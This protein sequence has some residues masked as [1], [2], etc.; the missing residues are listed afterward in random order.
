M[1]E[2]IQTHLALE[3][4]EEIVDTLIAQLNTFDPAV[5]AQ[6]NAAY[7]TLQTDYPANGTRYQQGGVVARFLQTLANIPEVQAVIGPL[8]DT[9]RVPVR[10]GGLADS[11]ATLLDRLPPTL[12]SPPR[13]MASPPLAMDPPPPPPAPAPGPPDSLSTS[14]SGGDDLQESVSAR[15]RGEAARIAVPEAAPPPTLTRYPHLDCPDQATINQKVSL[16]VQLLLEQLDAQSSGIVIEDTATADKLPEIELVLR[17]SG[18][19]IEGSNTRLLHIERA[20]DS[21]ERFVFVPRRLGEET[22]RVDFYQ[23]GRWIGTERRKLLVVEQPQ[24]I[25]RPQPVSSSPLDVTLRPT[26][27]PPDLELSIEVDEHDGRTLIFE[28]HSSSDDVGYNHAK[29]GKVRLEGSPL[30]K[31]QTVY[32]ELSRM[33]RVVGGTPVEQRLAEM[34]LASLGSELWN[35]LIPDELKRQYSRFK[36]RVKSLLIT[37]DEPWVPW[38]MLKPHRVTDDG[39]IQ[40]D[41]FWC[42][43]FAVA[44]WLSGPWA[45]DELPVGQAR[46]VAPTEVNLASVRE[47]VAFIE[48]L[49]TL[50]PGM[51]PLSVFSQRLQVLDW[52]KAGGFS[53]LHFA[54]HGQFDATLPNDSAIALGDGPLRPSDIQAYFGKGPRPLVF[55]NACHGA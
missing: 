25:E 20:A 48:Q 5:Q 44:R 28:L 55:I 41:P 8:I 30:E 7:R 6:I 37:S 17:A 11:D 39:A 33:A 23:H 24:A 34:R 32:A 29:V 49:A 38:E 31:M 36:G 40:E 53:V 26:I 19:D 54:C 42:Q 10:R 14:A 1:P 43:Q 16:F 15:T 46:S 50:R 22:L 52:L 35:E 13:A 4:I 2:Q 47:E 18:C 45:A 51:V 9:T 21:E 12:A 3:R 27:P